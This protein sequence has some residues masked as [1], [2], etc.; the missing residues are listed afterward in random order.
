MDISPFDD[1]HFMR[2]ALIEA[3]KAFDMDE[4]PVGAVIVCNQKI[5]A[6]AHNFTER[7]NDFTA[8][9]EMQAFTSA[10]EY[11]GSKYLNN[12]I[13]YIT[14]EPCIMCAG[15]SFWTRIGKIVFG[16]PDEKRGYQRLKENIL[17]PSTEIQGGIL[18][19]DCAEL[20]KAFFASK[21]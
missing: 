17:H 4:V 1:N 8:H 2:Q 9:A 7:L 14:L 18:K 21:R 11:L 20:L 13:I 12:C 5:I 6:R 16:A 15:A 3:Q 19:D 10:S